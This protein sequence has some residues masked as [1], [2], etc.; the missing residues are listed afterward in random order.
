MIKEYY[1]L[2]GEKITEQEALEHTEFMIR[3]SEHLSDLP[4]KEEEHIINGKPD[5][6]QYFIAH[7]ESEA[8]VFDHLSRKSEQFQIKKRIMAEDFVVD[9]NKDYSLTNGNGALISKTVYTTDDPNDN[10]ICIHVLDA[11]TRLPIPFRTRKYCYKTSRNGERY[12]AIEFLYDEN[13]LLREAIEMPYN[14]DEQDWNYYD[15]D[16]FQLLQDKNSTDLSYYKN[17]DLL[18]GY[19][20]HLLE[21]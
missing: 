13:G 1:G 16:H 21:E 7:D 11:Q 17:S 15:R 5:F 3:W 18:P 8:E 14:S 20:L 2:S 9:V 4:F 6:I 10:Y 19:L 12:E